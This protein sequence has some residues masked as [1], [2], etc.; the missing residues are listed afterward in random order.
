LGDAIDRETSLAALLIDQHA[1]DYD[2]GIAPTNRSV[3]TDAGHALAEG[4]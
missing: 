4:F 1:C 2:C 3:R